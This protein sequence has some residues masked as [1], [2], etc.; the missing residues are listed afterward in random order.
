MQNG[1]RTRD[2]NLLFVT[3]AMLST[4]THF[5]PDNRGLLI[6]A[7]PSRRKIGFLRMLWS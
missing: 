7:N 3:V 2:S 6:K 1:P 5:V 4:I